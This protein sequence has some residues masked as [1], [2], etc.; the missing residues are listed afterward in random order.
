MTGLTTRIAR[1]ALTAAATFAFV[2]AMLPKPPP[3]PGSPSDTVLHMLAFAVLGTLSAIAFPKTSIP[4][5]VLALGVFGAAIEVV[6]AIP[7]LH[8]DS[9]LLDLVVDVVA[10]LIATLATR[11][12]LRRYPLP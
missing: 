5:L 7:M 9:E 12:I 1:Y 4:W 10:A 6:Q 8:R 3:I 2:M 11:A